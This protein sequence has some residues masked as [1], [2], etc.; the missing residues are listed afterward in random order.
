MRLTDAL[1]ASEPAPRVTHDKPAH[2][3]G[4][5][6]GYEW[7]GNAGHITT[8]PLADRPTTW[9]AYLVDAGLDPADVEV[10][11]PV[12][13]RG[14]DTTV[15]KRD[16]EGRRYSEVVRAR[17]YRL[18][19]RRRA[20]KVDLD[21]LVRAAR[22]RTRTVPPAL[23]AG[24]YAFVVALGDLQLG[25]GLASE[26]PILTPAGWTKHGD[27][28]AGMSVYGR[29]GQ[30]KRVLDVLPTT[31]RGLYE[32]ELGD[33][34]SVV[35]DESHLWSGTRK[36]HTPDKRGWVRRAGVVS[37]TELKAIT[38][39]PA[40]ATR[41]F[42]L[43]AAGAIEFPPR[44]LL[45]DPYVFG[46]W[47]GDGKTHTGII[48]V[49]AEDADMIAHLGHRVPSDER[50]GQMCAVRIPGL[51]A[52]LR[53]LG[54]L[55]AKRIPEQYLRGSVAQR[56]A[57]VQGLMDTDGYASEIG[58]CEFTNTNRQII[59]SMLF[60]LR[61]LGI[62]CRIAEHVGRISGRPFKTYWRINFRAPLPVFRL[63]R[64]AA[65]QREST[66]RVDM[67]RAVRAVRYV[68]RGDAQCITVEG[69]LYLAGEQL[70]VTHNC[71]GD[72][73]EGTVARFLDKT[74][75]AVTRYRR[76]AKG[77]PVY[78]FHL[79][80][81]IEGFVSQGGA[82]AW[83]TTLTTTEQVRL[84]RR[85]VLEQVKAFAA[86]APRVILAGVPG[87]H[88]EAHRPLH[89]Y[90]DSWAID[91]LSAVQDALQLAGG[92]DHVSVHA[93]ARDELT[94]TFDVCGTTVGLAHGHQFRNGDW[95]KWWSGQ[96]HG[97]QPIG[98]AD[99][100]LTGHFHHLRIVRESRTF[101]QVP[102]LESESTWFRHTRGGVSQ[103]GIV[104]MLVGDGSWR[105][106]EVL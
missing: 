39:Q 1:E 76:Y 40:S 82:N 10:I 23:V 83:R 97:R 88:D 58:A 84:Y 59:D 38:E 27:L 26:T 105:S 85:L 106:L 37:L 2:P 13:V 71:D 72:G 53:T 47:L 65:R 86:V 48:G 19:T 12:Q 36:Y 45:V 30:P 96:S 63:P 33:G 75:A 15:A 77:C 17:Y 8:G 103:P 64:K 16:T 9:D 92:Y 61:S 91:A 102:A 29:D 31:S 50:A 62:R 67:Y 46:A 6:P 44:N 95:Q 4:W 98:D 100:L 94:L 104:T 79:G 18:N 49:G 68:G 11:E 34:T 52:K 28:R 69:G 57:L 90:G 101:L 55:G 14:W 66:Q 80:D 54:V 5:E 35:C 60:L 20:V 56:L 43:D 41:P 99:M 24:S 70:T 87:N 7:D 25:K 78:L 74:A 32:V 51:T 42:V 93:P 21:E 3:K 73:V 22:R 81:C 89:T